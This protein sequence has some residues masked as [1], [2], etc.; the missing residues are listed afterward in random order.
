[1]A[2]SWWKVLYRRGAD[3]VLNGHEHNYE[4]FA[5]LSPRGRTRK[6]GVRQFVVGT[7]GY[8]LY[9][10]G[11]S[12]R[13]SQRRIVSHG[14]LVLR[15]GNSRYVWRFIKTGGRVADHGGTACHG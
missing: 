6:N 3:V 8:H 10:F 4:R 2:A 7:G 9:G 11:G 1:V 5:K 14:V 15:L 13:G 12:A